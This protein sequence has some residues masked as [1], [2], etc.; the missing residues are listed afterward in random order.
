M[1]ELGGASSGSSA[2]ALPQGGLPPLS[3]SHRVDAGTTTFAM[4]RAQE[5]AER[6]ATFARAV[7]AIPEHATPHLPAVHCSA[8]LLR[9][10]SAEQLV[11]LARCVPPSEAAW[12]QHA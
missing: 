10:T 4:G 3:E 5:V 6:V 8:L 9:I 2:L 12:S 7:A 1:E 11:R